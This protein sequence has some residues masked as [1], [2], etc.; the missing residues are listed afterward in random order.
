MRNLKWVLIVQVP[1]RPVPASGSSR[2][3]WSEA[4]YWLFAEAGGGA[5]LPWG[6]VCVMWGSG[7]PSS[8]QETQEALC[9][10]SLTTL[11]WDFTGLPSDGRSQGL[12][13]GQGHGSRGSGCIAFQSV[14]RG[15]KDWSEEP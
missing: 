2:R 10:V 1:Q 15:A 8:C 7:K 3:Q 13:L 14:V 9:A 5:F 4:H 11:L 12:A 6:C